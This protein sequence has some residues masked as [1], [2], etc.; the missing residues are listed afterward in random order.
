MD[1]GRPDPKQYRNTRWFPLMV[2]L[3]TEVSHTVRHEEGKPWTRNRER[4]SWVWKNTVH[5][6][7]EPKAS[8]G[9]KRPRKQLL[10]KL[11]GQAGSMCRAC[12]HVNC[13]WCSEGTCKPHWGVSTSGLSPA[14]GLPVPLCASSC[15]APLRRSRAVASLPTGHGCPPRGGGA[16]SRS[17]G[18]SD[19][20]KGGNREQI[21]RGEVGVW[22]GACGDC[23]RRVRRQLGSV[24]W[25]S[26]CVPSGDGWSL[27]WGC[28]EKGCEGWCS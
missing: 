16:G 3:G 19:R 28:S 9:P 25:T 23:K 20:S 4:S 17:A 1:K 18:H 22:C 15:L 13:H 21:W 2:P 27:S 8:K 24:G 10:S 26:G 6:K 11:W 12:W 14:Q 7:E 5:W